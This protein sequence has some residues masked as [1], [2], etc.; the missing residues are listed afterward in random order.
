MKTSHEKTKATGSLRAEAKTIDLQLAEQNGFSLP[1]T[2][3]R[4]GSFL[5]NPRFTNLER[6]H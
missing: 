4:D 2:S 5:A 6:G 1:C 3:V